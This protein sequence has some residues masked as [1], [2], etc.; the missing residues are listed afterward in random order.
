LHLGD[1]GLLIIKRLVT[2]P[3]VTAPLVTAPL[4]PELQ[5]VNVLLL[6]VAPVAGG[7]QHLAELLCCGPQADLKE[8]KN[9]QN[10]RRAD[11]T[12]ILHLCHPYALLTKI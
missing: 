7:G 12:T 6:A 3:L 10:E 11:Y 2:A 8:R 1:H 4:V 9:I 5:V